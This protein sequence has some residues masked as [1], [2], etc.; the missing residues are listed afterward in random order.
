[1][2]D[3]DESW[4]PLDHEHGTTSSESDGGLNCNEA[5]GGDINADDE[6]ESELERQPKMVSDLKQYI[7]M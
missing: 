4:T 6:V 5:E 2:A 7:G 3:H 1:M